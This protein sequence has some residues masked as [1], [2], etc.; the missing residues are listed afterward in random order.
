MRLASMEGERQSFGQSKGAKV[1]VA[2][3]Q[4]GKPPGGQRPSGQKTK[5]PK[6]TLTLQEREKSPLF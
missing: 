1:R 5:S 6:S 2:E 3:D 4:G